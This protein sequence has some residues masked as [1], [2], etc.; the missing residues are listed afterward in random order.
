MSAPSPGQLNV[1]QRVSMPQTTYLHVRGR[2]AAAALGLSVEM[3]PQ[4]R[5]DP[6]PTKR[7]Q[8]AYAEIEAYRQ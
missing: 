1:V 6:S 5:G 7:K 2:V 3:G 4:K 8:D